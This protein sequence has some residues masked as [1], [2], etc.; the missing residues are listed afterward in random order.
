MAER[1]RRPSAPVSA[2]EGI[3]LQRSFCTDDQKFCGLQAR[4]S[5]KDV[6]DLIASRS[7]NGG[8]LMSRVSA[9]KTNPDRVLWD[10]AFAEVMCREPARVEM[11]L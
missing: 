4:L 1:T 9:R 6:R 11:G 10:F 5:C 2:V 8:A 3:V 7:K